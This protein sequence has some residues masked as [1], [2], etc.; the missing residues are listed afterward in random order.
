[1]QIFEDIFEKKLSTQSSDKIVNYQM[2]SNFSKELSG[3]E[4]MYLRSAQEVIASVKSWI[5]EAKGYEG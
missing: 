3:R 5:A 1:V 4:S 2:K